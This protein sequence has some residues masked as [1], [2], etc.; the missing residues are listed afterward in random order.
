MAT[1]THA[2]DETGARRPAYPKKGKSPAIWFGAAGTPRTFSMGQAPYP[3]LHTKR[4]Y[5]NEGFV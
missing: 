1:T 2:A 4:T 5:T 3:I